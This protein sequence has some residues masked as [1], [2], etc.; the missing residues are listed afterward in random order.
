MAAGRDWIPFIVDN[1]W[2][3]TLNTLMRIAINWIS[4]RLSGVPLPRLSQI[5]WQTAVPRTSRYRDLPWRR[6]GF[7]RV[8]TT[9]WDKVSLL[10][11]VNLLLM[12]AYLS[13][14]EAA[15]LCLFLDLNGGLAVGDD[16]GDALM[17]VVNNV[18][19]L[20]NDVSTGLGEKIYPI[21]VKKSGS[22]PEVVELI[23]RHSA[24]TVKLGGLCDSPAKSIAQQL[25]IE[26]DTFPLLFL[27]SWM[28][29]KHGNQWRHLEK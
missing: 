20:I 29:A 16:V 6:C 7:R 19:K 26:P 25:A 12:V 21:E 4:W 2:L 28:G 13:K 15:F 24:F 1:I 8:H 27:G 11:V 22:S 9:L 10:V 5:D 3:L 23:H 17:A 14:D 18:N